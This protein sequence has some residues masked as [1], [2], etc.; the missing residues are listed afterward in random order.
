MATA[1]TT[2]ETTVKTT[3]VTLTLTLHEAETLMA[4]GQ[5]I[6]GCPRRS[7]RRHTDAIFAALAEAGIRTPPHRV[8]PNRINAIYFDEEA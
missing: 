1:K 5:Y 4:A 8:E 7:R 3:G 2:T 6:G